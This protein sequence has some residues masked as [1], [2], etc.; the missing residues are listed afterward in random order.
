MST[1]EVTG[2]RPTRL[3][4]WKSWW[5]FLALVVIGSHLFW[6]TVNVTN[7]RIA[8][9]GEILTIVLAGFL[10]ITL[11][12]MPLTK[13][14]REVIAIE[15]RD[16]LNAYWFEHNRIERVER[17]TQIFYKLT[18][19]KI[20]VSRIYEPV[21]VTVYAF[22]NLIVRVAN[23]ERLLK[24][25]AEEPGTDYG[26]WLVVFRHKPDP[27]LDDITAEYHEYAL[28][29]TTDWKILINGRYIQDGC[30]C[31]IPV[32]L[33]SFTDISEVLMFIRK[34]LSAKE[35][36]FDYIAGFGI[37]LLDRAK[38]GGKSEELRQ[39]KIALREGANIF[40]TGL[41]PD[42]KE[43]AARRP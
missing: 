13:K 26:I 6:A 4:W 11:V 42:F 43:L 37:P 41:H 25:I 9:L 30:K 38:Q 31:R 17:M 14:E 18:G 12:W 2:D 33:D 39:L 24:L 22:S 19:T 21:S 36:A 34:N 32:G 10:V 40:A 29:G 8:L 15:K 3:P 23:P 35:A 20:D 1:P 28:G 16:R 5:F 27:E 7:P